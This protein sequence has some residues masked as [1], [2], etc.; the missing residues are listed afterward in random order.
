MYK[1][2]F[3]FQERNI[4]KFKKALRKRVEVE[5]DLD[6]ERETTFYYFTSAELLKLMKFAFHGREKQFSIICRI[7]ES[8]FDRK[9]SAKPVNQQIFI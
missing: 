6:R 9:S 3:I 8:I 2:R 7:Y 5:E 4:R 1:L